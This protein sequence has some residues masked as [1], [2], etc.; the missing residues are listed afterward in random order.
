MYWD[1]VVLIVLVVAVVLFFK[2]FSSFVYLI[3]ILDV[4]F[5]L[6]SFV[7]INLGVP[8]L[9]NLIDKYF[10]SSMAGL[11]GRYSSGII[12][13][14]LLWVLFVIYVIFEGYLIRIFCKRK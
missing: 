9:S 14:V 13:T 5:R 12:E 2:K 11:V 6:L 3:V 7:S 8:E 4:L 10:P 1:L